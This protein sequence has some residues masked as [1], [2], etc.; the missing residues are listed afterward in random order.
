MESKIQE[1][2]NILKIFKNFG[3]VGS[4]QILP[5]KKKDGTF[6]KNL[7][8]DHSWRTKPETISILKDREAYYI[9]TGEINGIIVLDLDNME[10]E[11]NR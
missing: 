2:E 4:M 11:E 6:Q 3:N 5:G 7:K 1:N 10:Q 9:P 8:P